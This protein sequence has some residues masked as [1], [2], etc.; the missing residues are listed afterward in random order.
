MGYVKR[1]ALVL[2]LA[3]AAGV[4]PV[5]PAPRFDEARDQGRTGLQRI[6]ADHRWQRRTGAWLPG[7]GSLCRTQGSIGRADAPVFAALGSERG[8][9]VRPQ[10]PLEQAWPR[11]DGV[12]RRTDVGEASVHSQHPARH[13]GQVCRERVPAR[14]RRD[15]YRVAQRRLHR[16]SPAG[17]VD[18]RSKT[19]GPARPVVPRPC[20]RVG[21]GR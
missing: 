12:P 21:P 14:G 7:G 10:G 4:V 19:S 18:G 9:D 5:G 2:V 16:G 17:G 1:G 15:R 13:P 3:L 20:H 6:L 11:V 8:G